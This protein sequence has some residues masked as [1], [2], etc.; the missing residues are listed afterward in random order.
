MIY[1]HQLFTEQ[2]IKTFLTRKGFVLIEVETSQ[3]YSVSQVSD[4]TIHRKC[5]LAVRY[6][7]AL[8]KLKGDDGRIESD[9]ILELQWK[10]VFDKEMAQHLVDIA[11]PVL[12]NDPIIGGNRISTRPKAPT[13]NKLD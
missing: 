6:P 5:L 3:L 12:Y 9:K 7:I 10:T 11:I 4:K 2:Q 8:E 1:L 13:R